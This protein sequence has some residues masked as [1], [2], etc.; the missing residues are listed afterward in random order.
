[1]RRASRPPLIRI[2]ETGDRTLQAKIY[3][4]IRSSII[5]GIIGADGRLPSTRALAADLGV[6][7]T[8]VLRAFEYLKAAGYLDPRRGSGTFVAPELPSQAP[9]VRCAQRPS[10]ANHPPSQFQQ[11]S[12]RGRTL[13]QAPLPDRRTPG[14]PRA[15]RLGTPAVDLFP[16]RLWSR[17]ARQCMKSVGSARL[18][19]SGS[20]GHT[21]LR[22]AI[23][24]QV[25]SRGT[26]CDPRQVVIVAGAQRGLDL[27]F[28]LLLDPG[29]RVWMEEPGYPGAR[30]AFIGADASIVSVPVDEEGMDVDKATAS[31]QCESVRLAF[32]TPSHQFPTGVTMSLRRRQQLLAWARRSHAWI[33]EDDYDCDFR[34]QAKPLPCLHALDP[35]GRVIYVGTFSKTTFPALRL[36][37]LILPTHLV[38]EVARARCA[39]DVHPPI[40]EQMV[41]AEF[42]TSGHYERHLRRMQGAYAERLDALQRAVNQSGAPLRLRPVHS[43]LHAVADLEDSDAE[44]VW[45][46]ARSRNIE[47]MPLS[48]Y[49]VDRAR[50][51]SSLLLGFG[52]ISAP[53]IRAGVAQLALAIEAVRREAST[54]IDPAI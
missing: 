49:C 16:V 19:Y 38:S 8:T 45:R 22:E 9:R 34:Y 20:L 36:G 52:S 48:A 46:E 37:F 11:L 44:A 54:E 30:N 53:A 2:D 15:F 13:A 4:S 51:S 33:V 32:V 17:I 21:A 35:D 27:I 40:F 39:S 14:A 47:S 26:R 43:G 29:D 5:S 18:D 7:R 10:A 12:E 23:A 31:S 28:H 6:S 3:S 24:A 42:M 50:A 1:M 41:L 25:R